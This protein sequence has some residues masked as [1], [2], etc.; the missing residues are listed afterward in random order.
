MQCTDNLRIIIIFFVKFLDMILENLKDVLVAAQFDRARLMV[1]NNNINFIAPAVILP[2]GEIPRR[3][4][5]R[6]RVY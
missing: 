2:R 6:S 5:S 4:P 1:G 3:H